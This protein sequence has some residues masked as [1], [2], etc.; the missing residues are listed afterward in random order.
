MEL[1]SIVVPVYNAERYLSFCLD[2]LVNQTYPN[3]EVF[4]VDDGSFDSS[5]K[6]CDEYAAKY[7][8]VHVIH[9]ENSGVSAARNTALDQI[10]GGVRSFRR[11]R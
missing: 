2:S 10:R 9:R 11:C 7:S 4:L 5:P 3:K 6:I 1:L 8:F